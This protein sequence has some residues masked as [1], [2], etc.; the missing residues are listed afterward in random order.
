MVTNSNLLLIEIKQMGVS[1]KTNVCL[2]LLIFKLKDDSHYEWT[3]QQHPRLRYDCTIKFR[4]KFTCDSHASL[5]HVVGRPGVIVV[6][7][8]Q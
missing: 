7:L 1:H 3:Q 2:Y 5:E 6:K 4:V 8:Q